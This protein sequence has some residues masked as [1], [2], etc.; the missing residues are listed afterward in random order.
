[1]KIYSS[2]QHRTGTQGERGW[3]FTKSMNP[4]QN[5]FKDDAAKKHKAVRIKQDKH[6]KF[7]AEI[8]ETK[9]SRG[10][11]RCKDKTQQ[12]LSRKKNKRNSGSEWSKHYCLH[13]LTL[14]PYK[15]KLTSGHYFFSTSG[16][17]WREMRTPAGS[18][19]L[20][21]YVYLAISFVW[22]VKSRHSLTLVLTAKI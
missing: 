3:V 11:A 20:L 2:R 5:T 18:L 4:F 7:V 9:T 12:Q 14:L 21:C 19:T 8:P 10:G 13:P 1:M 15:I 6:C 17:S 22:T 16:L